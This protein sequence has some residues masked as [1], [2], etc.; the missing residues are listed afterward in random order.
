MQHGSILG[1]VNFFSTEHRVDVGLQAAFIGQR[2]EQAHRLI[3]DAM[4]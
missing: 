1:D 4:F 3:G 2:D